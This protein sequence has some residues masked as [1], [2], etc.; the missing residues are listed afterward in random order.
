MRRAALRI[1]G[2]RNAGCPLRSVLLARRR[3]QPGHIRS[4]R[5]LIMRWNGRT[6]QRLPGPR[7]RGASLHDVAALSPH[8][9]WAVG[10]YPVD[11]YGN[12]GKTL[13]VHWNGMA[14]QRVRSPSPADRDTLYSVAVTS[15]SNAW[16]VGE[17]G[18]KTLILHWNGRSWRQVPSPSPRRRSPTGD[19]LAAVT[20]TSARDA[21]AVGT[22][23]RPGGVA[24]A[25]VE[26][27]NGKAWHTVG[28]ASPPLNCSD[29]VNGL[30]GGGCHGPG[31]LGG[32]RRR[33]DVR[34]L[35]S[36]ALEWHRLEN[37]ARTHPA[38]RARLDPGRRDRARRPQHVGSRKYRLRLSAYP[39]LERDHL[40]AVSQ[41]AC[42]NRGAAI[43]GGRQLRHHR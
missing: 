10:G 12:P 39:A 3:G 1:R 16:A 37:S 26:H 22:D 23:D 20:A 13:I 41:P 40:A 36:R 21:W 2:R 33:C 29:D 38:A 19:G 18:A 27:W 34:A 14:W 25:L 11:R 24:G 9:A 6:W 32:R 15:A 4:D 7:L 42:L 43:R 35:L 8:D 17:T 28:S 5:A 31:C 30:V